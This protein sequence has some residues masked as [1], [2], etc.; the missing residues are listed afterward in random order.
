[1]TIE[2]EAGKGGG[3]K[4]SGKEQF[5]LELPNRLLMIAAAWEDLSQNSPVAPEFPEELA[6][7]MI[8]ADAL[9]DLCLGKDMA[10]HAEDLVN[11]GEMLG[12]IP[13][14]E[15]IE[16]EKHYQRIGAKIT[17]LIADV[18][19]EVEHCFGS[20][21]KKPSTRDDFLAKKTE[22]KAGGAVPDRSGDAKPLGFPGA[23]GKDRNVY[24]ISSDEDFLGEC[25]TQIGHYGYTAHALHTFEAYELGMRLETP[26]AVVVD[27]DLAKADARLN[28]ELTEFQSQKDGIPTPMIVVGGEGDFKSRLSA[29]RA[30]SSAFFA[31]PVNVSLLLDKLDAIISNA[32]VSE[33]FRILVVEDSAT[34]IRFISRT[35]EHAGMAVR[36]EQTPDLVLPAIADFHPD[37]ILMDMYMPLCDGQELSKLIRQY[38]SYTSIPIVFL[39][40]E[41]DVK[42]QLAAMQIGADDFL[43]KPIEPTHLVTSVTT[44]V[45]RHRILSSF[46]VK[47]SLTGLLNHTKLKQG[48]ERALQKA[49]RSK[50]PMAFAMVD[51]DFFKKVNDTYGH[52]MGDKVIKSLSRLLQKRLR[53]TD[54]IGRYGG[55]EFAVILWDTDAEGANRIINSIRSDFSKIEHLHEGTAFSCTFSAGV[56]GFPEYTDAQ[57]L[58]NAADKAL[59]VAKR[60]GRNQVITATEENVSSS[61]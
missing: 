3:K 28:G 34:M 19:K 31:K 37:L 54:S 35:L 43:T 27:L 6:T 9:K 13:E 18:E 16:R 59:Y 22:I 29:V 8:K 33:P 51:I 50:I 60:G 24:V 44:R 56:A 47:D 52:P 4:N 38:E 57:S 15:P 36:V 21:G 46:M 11:I 42:K 23:S 7:C 14:V 45:Q 55:E 30:G 41:T 25:S 32:C 2:S 48:V 53:K 26:L 17:G 40:S 61:E 58:S 49:M 39:S 10:A 1:M 12:A 20:E 5:L